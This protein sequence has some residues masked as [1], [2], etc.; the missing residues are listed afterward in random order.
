MC[1]RT[2][3][4]ISYTSIVYRDSSVDILMLRGFWRVWTQFKWWCLLCNSS[5]VFTLVP[6]FRIL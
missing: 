3:A 2:C 5:I 4:F 1:V 6:L